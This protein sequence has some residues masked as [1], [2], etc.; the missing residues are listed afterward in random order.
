[1]LTP[2]KIGKCDSE[3]A[4]QT[5]LFCWI[6]LKRI[7]HPELELELSCIFAIKNE[8]KSGN[9]IAGS[10]NKAAGIKRGVADIMIPVSRHSKHG[11]FVEMKVADT[12][13]GKQSQAQKDFAMK[14]KKLDYGYC[15][16]FGWQ[17]AASV[18]AKWFGINVE[19][20]LETLTYCGK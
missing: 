7:E 6:S 11:L 3:Q 19:I 15:L 14:I 1:M 13:K 12:R 10:H 17:S 2:E 4:Q 9:V 18:I 8:E 20:P 5:A 16:C